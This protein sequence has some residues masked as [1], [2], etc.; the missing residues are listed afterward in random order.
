[1][2]DEI[3]YELE[4]IDDNLQ[5]NIIAACVVCLFSAYVAVLLRFVSRRL[6]RTPLGWD[7]YLIV[8]ALVGRI[9]TLASLTVLTM[10]PNYRFSH[11]PL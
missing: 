10:S 9:P 6:I 11:L 1:M 4:H 3:K 5:P 8:V 7:D 2:D